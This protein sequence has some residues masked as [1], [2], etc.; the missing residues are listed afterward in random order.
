M[1]M[2]RILA[3]AWL[4]RTSVAFVSR[5]LAGKGHAPA[6]HTRVL[7]A[8]AT[9]RLFSVSRSDIE[10]DAQSGISR[11][12]TLRAMLSSH[13][14]PGSIG[15]ASPNG[16]L[17]PVFPVATLEDNDEDETPE[18]V[19]TI[20]GSTALEFSNLHPHL[21]PLARSKSTGNY[22][23]ALRRAFAEDASYENSSK[24]PWPIVE[25]RVGGPGMRLL[26]LNSEYLMRRIACEVDFEDEN[27]D[28]ENESENEN[29]D[30]NKKLIDLYNED[31]GKGILID[32]G[33]DQP[34]EKG[35]VKNLGYGVDK[36]V[37][38]RVGPFPD[39]YS[40]LAL[41]HAKRGD[42]SSSLIAAE[43][44]NGKISGFASTF[45]FYASLLDT[46]PNRSEETRDAARMCLRMPLSSI[47]LG[48]EDFRDVGIYGQL[49]SED[50]SDEEIF[51]KLQIMYEKMRDHENEDPRATGG[52]GGSNDM[53]PEQMAIDEA[54]YL[55]DICSLTGS[56]WSAVRPKLAE[57]YKSVGRDDMANFVNPSRYAA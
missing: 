16:D 47:G 11:L 7:T 13:G 15:C 57:I 8:T 29:N 48:P 38:L 39:I 17:E 49:A 56:K 45:L 32:K 20:A 10:A 4:C 21:Y 33:L 36:Y 43:A 50:D 24:A 26:A 40:K 30:D 42:E 6:L 46:F 44:A 1:R 31:L 55:L 35:S 52:V 37:L 28:D 34:Y 12:A 53:T 22:V 19:A 41:G 54:N 14:A 23:C 18:L 9:T 5:E 27:D 25:A 2:G 51:A 3:A